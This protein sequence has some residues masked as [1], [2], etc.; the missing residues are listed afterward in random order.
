MRS[1]G[2]EVD[3]R[4][5]DH[6][7]QHRLRRRVEAARLLRQ[8]RRRDRQHRRRSS[9]W[10]ACRRASGSPCRPRAAARRGA[11]RSR[12]APARAGL[13]AV[14][15]GRA[16]GRARAPRAG[17]TACLRAGRAAR[18]SS[19]SRRII[20]VMPVA[21]GIRPERDLGQAELDLRVV[22]RDAAVR[23][24]RHLPAAAERRAVRAARPPACPASRACGSSLHRLDLGE[25]GRRVFGLQPHH[26]LEVGAG[27]EG[28]SWPRPAPCP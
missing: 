16:P 13:G 8:H 24:Q 18:P 3:L 15:P 10:P 1:R 12:P 27:E 22:D 17:R 14:A 9:G 21:P 6:R 11:R 4:A 20:F 7:G 25:D 23:G 28:A 19:P 5:F 2:V 26:A